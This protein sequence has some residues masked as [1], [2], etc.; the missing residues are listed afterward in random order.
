M[1]TT[2]ITDGIQV[3]FDKPLNSQ[4]NANAFTLAVQLQ[5]SLKKNIRILTSVT[6][7]EIIGVAGDEETVNEVLK[8]IDVN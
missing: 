8:Y 6:V 3:L 1:T 7:H 2:K 5:K 4:T